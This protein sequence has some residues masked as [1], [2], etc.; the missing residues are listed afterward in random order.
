MYNSVI[1][2]TA[3]SSQIVLL[4]PV[5]LLPRDVSNWIPV[6]R[7]REGGRE[8]GRERGREG[9]RERERENNTFLWSTYASQ[10]I[11]IF[12]RKTFGMSKSK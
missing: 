4:L 5:L 10:T 9:G 1:K 2:W 6:M 3:S 12:F 8:G 7:E 11:L